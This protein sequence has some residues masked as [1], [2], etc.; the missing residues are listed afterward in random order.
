MGR[1]DSY[2]LS[3]SS[4]TAVATR[5]RAIGRGRSPVRRQVR[6]DSRWAVRGWPGRPHPTTPTS[7]QQSCSCRDT[8]LRSP[9]LPYSESGEVLLIAAWPPPFLRA[10][11]PW[12]KARFPTSG[13]DTSRPPWVSKR[14]AGSTSMGASPD[15]PIHRGS[16]VELPIRVET[17]PGSGSRQNPG[18]GRPCLSERTPGRPSWMGRPI[19]TWGAGQIR[20][21][22]RCSGRSWCTP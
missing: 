18:S 6:R 5:G 1:R 11:I 13:E 15:D 22:A 2:S 7:S 19:W 4:S 21:V 20:R 16:E 9:M 10:G 14:R 8:P 17:T 12:P 3:P